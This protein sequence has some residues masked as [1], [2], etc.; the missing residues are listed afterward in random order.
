MPVFSAIFVTVLAVFLTALLCSHAGVIGSFLN[1]LDVPG[2]RK[3]HKNVTPLMGGVVLLAAFLPTAVLSVLLFTSRA[4]VYSLTIWLVAV[5]AMTIIGIADDR[6]SL[7]PRLRLIV[8]FLIFGLVAFF[9]PAFNVRLLDFEYLN[10]SLGLGTRGIAIVFTVICCVGLVNAINMADGKNGLVIGLCIGWLALLFLRAPNAYAPL[11]ILLIAI[12][13]V[14]LIFNLQSKLFLG[15]GGAYGLATAI[16]LLAIATYNYSG[17]HAGRS[18]TVE[19][20]FVLF[21]IPVFDSFRLIYSRMRKGKSPMEGDRDH[22][23]HHLQ[24]G[25]GWPA[26]LIVY[27]IIALV[28]ATFWIVSKT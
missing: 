5:M 16:S 11:I 21:A 26:G 13:V 4:N 1:L 15:D 14:L 17:P 22:L 23:H 10:I 9:E 12:L 27:W 2:E 3:K 7:S 24:D 20:I 28:P 18:I 25:F 8:S 19:G 6:H